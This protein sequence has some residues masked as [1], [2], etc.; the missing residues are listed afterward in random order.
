MNHASVL[1]D[2]GIFRWLC[3]QGLSVDEGG[4]A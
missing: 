1:E 4:G 2:I 3:L